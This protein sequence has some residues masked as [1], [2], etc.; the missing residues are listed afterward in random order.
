MPQAHRTVCANTT[1]KTQDSMSHVTSKD[2]SAPLL[3]FKNGHCATVTVTAALFQPRGGKELLDWG[4]AYPGPLGRVVAPLFSSPRVLKSAARAF[5]CL[6]GQT[7]TS[8]GT[9]DLAESRWKGYTG[10]DS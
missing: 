4:P 2:P 6:K 3:L 1:H 7:D 5:K 10:R 8:E 9:E